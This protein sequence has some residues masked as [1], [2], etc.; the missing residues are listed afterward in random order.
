MSSI[1]D[2][3]L[4]ASQQLYFKADK[5]R[6]FDARFL[7]FT[8]RDSGVIDLIGLGDERSELR[9][10]LPNDELELNRELPLSYSGEGGVRCYYID[11]NGF[12]EPANGSITFYSLSVVEGVAVFS[13]KF[14]GHQPNGS[15]E[16]F[17]AVG[18]GHFKGITRPN[19]SPS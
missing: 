13:F 12:W 9:F 3:K 5:Y 2:K 10:S 15:I 18:G 14:S 7:F 6:G 4:L 17:Q 1:A 11:E 19:V 8:V 16:D